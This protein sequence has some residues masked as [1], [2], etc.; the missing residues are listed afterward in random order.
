[1]NQR[2]IDQ[3]INAN[4]VLLLLLNVNIYKVVGS[5]IILSRVGGGGGGDRDGG[6]FSTLNRF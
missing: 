3:N 6:Q 1:M 5:I 4:I 2:E